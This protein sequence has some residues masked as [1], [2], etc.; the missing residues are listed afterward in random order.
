VPIPVLKSLF[1]PLHS[2]NFLP[3]RGLLDLSL[4]SDQNALHFFGAT[5]YLPRS[6]LP[7]TRSC[8]FLSQHADWDSSFPIFWM[9]RAALFPPSSP[10]FCCSPSSPRNLSDTLLSINS[11]YQFSDSLAFFHLGFS[12]FPISPKGSLTPF[13]S[14]PLQRLST[15]L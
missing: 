9:T 15:S 3:Q 6:P 11:F 12:I 14:H 5:G 10:H 13:L 8:R 7:F 2:S 1:R 4:D